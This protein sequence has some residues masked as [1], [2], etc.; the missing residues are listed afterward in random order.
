MFSF[1]GGVVSMHSHGQLPTELQKSAVRA[2]GPR[3]PGEE[4]HGDGKGR[5]GRAR[6]T[7]ARTG[8]AHCVPLGSQQ[9]RA[10]RCG[11]PKPSEASASLDPRAHQP[12]QCEDGNAS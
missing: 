7:A 8:S 10:V 1:A 6:P 11:L 5:V 2:K 3:R 12:C 9:T 4:T